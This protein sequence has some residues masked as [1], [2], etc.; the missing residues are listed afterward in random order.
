MLDEPRLTALIIE[1]PDTDVSYIGV[2]RY[3]SVYIGARGSVAWGLISFAVIGPLMDYGAKHALYI[4]Y[5]NSTCCETCACLHARR[6]APA[7]V[8][9]R[10][11]AP[12]R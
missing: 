1:T 3:I 7:L 11:A 5:W 10:A 12:L 9:T 8:S 2:Y 6:R 4:V